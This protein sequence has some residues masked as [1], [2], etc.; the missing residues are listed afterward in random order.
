MTDPKIRILFTEEQIR[1]FGRC[2]K[3]G[4][5]PPT[6]DHHPKCPTLKETP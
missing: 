3:C 1:S 4:F 6:Q 5:H 2:P